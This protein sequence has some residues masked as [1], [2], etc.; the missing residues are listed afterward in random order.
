MQNTPVGQCKAAAIPPAP[1]SRRTFWVGVGSAISVLVIWT[2][3]ILIA[4]V[5]AKGHLNPFDIAFVRFVFSGLIVLPVVFLRGGWLLDQLAPRPRLALARAAALVATAGVGYCSLSYSAF[6]FAPVSH[7]AVLLPGSLPLHTAV[8]AALLLGERFRRARLIGLAAIVAGNLLIGG[9]SLLQAFGGDDTWKGDVLFLGASMSW[10]L[11]SVLCRRWHLDAIPATCA[12]A[13]G[14]LVSYVPLFAIGA[15]TGLVPTRLASAPWSEIAFQ[16]VYQ[17][18]ISMLLAGV[19]FTQVVKTFG[20]VRTTMIMAV[21]PVLATIS[22]LPL[23]GE[24]MTA[25]GGVGL[26][27]V[28][29]GL[30]IGVG[31]QAGTSRAVLE[32]RALSASRL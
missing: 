14:C 29:L 15:A 19:A 13:I 28:T 31:A 26:A 27:C 22:A 1:P 16:A 25:A 9:T 7:A 17:G 8:L 10:A 11:Y 30:L 3:F 20:P 2:T 6:F 24:S 21:V 32:R 12:I 23:L 4:R 18:G 5:S